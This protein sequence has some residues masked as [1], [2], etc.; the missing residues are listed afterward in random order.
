VVKS[1]AVFEQLMAFVITM[2]GL[3]RYAVF[4]SATSPE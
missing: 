3:N 1:L 2:F 4:G